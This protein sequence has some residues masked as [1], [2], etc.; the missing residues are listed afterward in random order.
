[1]KGLIIGD[2]M[3]DKNYIV[4]MHVNKINQKKYIGVTKNAPEKRWINGNGY[5]R[6]AFYN[7][8]QKYGWDNFDHIIL[9]D[10]LSQSE[11]SKKEIEMI[12]YYQSNNKLFGYNVSVGGENGHNELWNDPE[13]RKN[14]IKERKERWENAEYREKLSKIMKTTMESDT[15]KQALSDSVKKRWNDGMFDKIFCKPVMC[16]ETGNIYKSA[17]E[18]SDST[19]ICRTDIG[20]CCNEEV[21]TAKGYHWIF[22]NGDNYTESDRK[23]MIEQIGSGRGIRIMCVETGKKY[24]SI[25]E[26]AKDVNVDNSSI[27]KVLKGKQ[28]TSAGYH[29]IYCK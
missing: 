10:K 26:A 27:G 15:Y 9:F 8:I 21:K 16:L 11:A 13:Y 4:Y 25:K 7:A 3:E 6:Q 23:L 19:N 12:S 20:K 5:K 28:K 17:K 2:N 18:A 14:Q 1:M 24:N 22:Y 29:W